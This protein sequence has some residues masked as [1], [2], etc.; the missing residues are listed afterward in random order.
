MLA[1]LY[2]MFTQPA[3]NVGSF[4]ADDNG[5]ATFQMVSDRVKVTACA[6]YIIINPFM[7]YVVQVVIP[8]VTA[9]V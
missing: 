8:N 3:G 6:S 2:Y 4:T 1:I 5:K 7:Y 9:S